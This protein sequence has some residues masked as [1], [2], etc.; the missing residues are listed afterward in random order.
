MSRQPC[1]QPVRGCRVTGQQT[2]TD[3]QM[4]GDTMTDMGNHTHPNGHRG[5]DGAA[6]VA[7]LEPL[8][9][10]RLGAVSPWPP[11]NGHDVPPAPGKLR[12]FDGDRLRRGSMWILASG[13]AAIAAI[14]SYSHIYDLGRAHGGSGVAARLLPLSVDMLILVGELMLLHE[15][16]GKGRRF[17]LG[18]VLV[19]SGILATL[20]ANVTYGAQYGVVG[21][22]I[23][24]WPAYSFILA[25]GGMVA[26][27]KR[28]A[29]RDDDEREADTPADTDTI[30][31]PDII[32]DT[33][34]DK[35]AAADTD[36][37]Q[38]A[39]KTPAR[40][41]KRPTGHDRAKATLKRNPGLSN[42][43]VA[44][45]LNVSEKTVQRAR[46]ELAPK[47]TP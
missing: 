8:P 33:Q 14:V 23:W 20:A 3:D 22:L 27:V 6:A 24:G 18:W 16:D 39:Q 25:A 44:K 46:S 29:S 47:D 34:P 5:E 38:A 4:T 41:A 17:V 7:T 2:R 21:A 32:T 9:F 42:P 13:V 30:P 12:R 40:T 45:R 11:R 15:A 26:V 43:E 10:P 28:G 31:V 36:K 1:L 37:P 35:T 19:W